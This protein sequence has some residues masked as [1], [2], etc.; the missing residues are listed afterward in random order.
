MFTLYLRSIGDA[1]PLPSLTII[2]TVRLGVGLPSDVDLLRLLAHRPIDG[3][4]SLRPHPVVGHLGAPAKTE[5]LGVVQHLKVVANQQRVLVGVQ[6]DAA[7]AVGEDLKRRRRKY[8]KR[9]KSFKSF[10]LTRPS[11]GLPASLH[12]RQRQMFSTRLKLRFSRSM[13]ASFASSQTSP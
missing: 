7:A 11:I 8:L 10:Q 12:F 9:L 4:L 13:F 1:V 6:Q 2:I 5:A 3:H